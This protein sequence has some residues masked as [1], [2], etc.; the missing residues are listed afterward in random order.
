VGVHV[1]GSVRAWECA[2]QR[3]HAVRHGC[4]HGCVHACQRVRAVRVLCCAHACLWC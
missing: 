2:Y 1:C 4:V 3:V